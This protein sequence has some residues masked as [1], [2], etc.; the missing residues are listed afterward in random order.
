MSVPSKHTYERV[1]VIGGGVIG[2]SWTALFLA[3]GL[4]VVVSDPMPDIDSRV[5]KQLAVI[6][7]TLDELGFDTSRLTDR[8]RFEPDIAKAVADADV[9]QENGPERMDLKQQIWA[10]IEKAAPAHTLFATST[11][12]LPATEIATALQHPE[13]LIVGHPFN[14]PHLVPLVEI[15]PGERTAPATV[16]A[17]VA[18]YRSLGKRPQVL[19]KEIQGFVANR[20]QSAL[21]RECVYLVAQGVVTEA[22]LDE[23]VTSSIGMRWAV[24]GPFRTFHLGGGPGGLAAF[25]THLGPTMEAIWPLLGSPTFDDATVAVLADQAKDLGEDIA[26]LAETRDRSQI[27]LMKALHELPRG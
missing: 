25:L 20:L 19:R 10:T 6:R 17:A 1:A 16:D 22:E 15:V 13:R 5:M 23:V 21:F 18:F 7:P 3:H 8:L 2:V 27:A 26:Q 14:P 4:E 11:S 9:V 24:A 12:S